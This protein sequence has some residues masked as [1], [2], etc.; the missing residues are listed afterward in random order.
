MTKIKNKSEALKLIKQKVNGEIIISYQ[1]IAD[2]TN[3]SKRQIIRFSKEIEKKDIDD[4]LIHGL[5]GKNSNNS[6]PTTE[7]EYIV[8]FKNQYPTISIQQFMDIYHEDII[9]N[10]K[11]NKDVKKYKLKIRSKSFFQHLFKTQG[12][13]SPVK[14]KSFK[15][16]ENAHSL[17][18]PSPRFGM[19]VMT[20]GTPHD[21]FGNGI[22]WSLHMTLDDAT[23]RILSG[24]FT[25]NESQD[26]YCHAFKLMF[27]KC[28]LPEVIYSDRTSI[29]W[30]FKENRKTQV[31]RMIDELGIE[32]IY[33][34][35]P[36]AKGKIERMN[37][38]I[39]NRLLNDIK[40]FHIKTYS[41]LNKWFNDFYID[42]INN[43]Y[44]YPAS[45]QE[46]SFV[47]LGSTD[48]IKI[49]C[50]KKESTILNGNMISI[51]NEYYIPINSS[52]ENYTFY[53]GTKVEVWKDVFDGKVR[54]FKN[55][56]IYDTRKIPGQRIDM[57]KKQQKRINDQKQLETLLKEKDERLKA[58]ANE[59][60]SS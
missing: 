21:W 14:H 3:F 52:D 2:I 7:I 8:E 37:E 58:R 24:W 15:H 16:N 39:Q 38:T 30:D 44:S 34:N 18:E 33:A 48:L 45:D 41:E 46:S 35:T 23:G 57:T 49:M 20:D 29:L 43:K 47:P 54:I 55:N 28:G 1:K 36:Q 5:T 6:A 11:K 31:A 50:I 10:K 13:K 4:L 27:I 17:R 42:Y 56:K 19:L 22:K 32:L 53:K 9:W 25:P 26:G 60:S 51:D 59:V 12:W 40:R